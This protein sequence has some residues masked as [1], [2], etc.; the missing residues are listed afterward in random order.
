MAKKQS[1]P[2]KYTAPGYV[3][4]SFGRTIREAENV[5]RWN[6]WLAHAWME[7]ARDMLSLDRPFFT[8]YN[9]CVDRINYYWSRLPMFRWY[10]EHTFWTNDGFSY[11]PTYLTHI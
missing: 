1:V 6:P 7:E 4:W 2:S 3:V 10:D 9:A 11:T 8:E 5:S